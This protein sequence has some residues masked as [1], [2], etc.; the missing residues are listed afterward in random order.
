MN[1]WNGWLAG[2][3]ST[4]IFEIEMASFRSHV[5]IFH[6]DPSKV[7]HA[8]FVSGWAFAEK[9]AAWNGFVELKGRR[10]GDISIGWPRPDVAQAFPSACPWPHVGFQSVFFLPPDLP[11]GRHKLD[12]VF[13]NRQGREIGRHR[14]ELRCG[15][16]SG[17]GRASSPAIEENPEQA[18][19]LDELEAKLLGFAQCSE[20]EL[21][22]RQHGVDQPQNAR[23]MIGRA[24]LHHLRACV[25]TVLRDRVAGDLIETGVWRGGACIFMRGVLHA[26]HDP[27]RVVWVAD[28][29]AG[30]PAP[31][32]KYPADQGDPHHTFAG[33]RI[34]PG[35]VKKGFEI[36]G[37]LDRQVRFL[38]GWF[39]Q[40]LP[41]ANIEKLSILRLDGDM[42]EST[43]DALTS[44]YPKLSP[45]GFCVIDDYG[46]LGSCRQAV[47]DYRTAQGIRE[48]IGLIDWTGAWWRKE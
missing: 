36:H 1:D 31:N 10:L 37:L 6:S 34:P 35:E 30:L 5:D 13:T 26:F 42:Y 18:H 23:T 47:H 22:M 14:Q 46:A 43:M 41:R 11:A 38:E 29:F 4:G 28:S 9:E 40:T 20:A 3:F 12:L 32:Q 16:P 44:L 24:R 45:G 8:W 17:A 21:M 48:P 33:L 27:C 15:P 7:S 39:S 25:E 2:N 19:A